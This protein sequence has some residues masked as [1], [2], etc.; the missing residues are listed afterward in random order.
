MFR[1]HKPINWYAWSLIL[2]ATLVLLGVNAWQTDRAIR[3]LYRNENSADTTK[4]VLRT[5]KDFYSA[6]QDAELGI[7][8]HLLAQN[9]TFLAPYFESLDKIKSNLL[10]L[11]GYPY[12]IEGQVD[13]VNQ[14]EQLLVNHLTKMGLHINATEEQQRDSYEAGILSPSVLESY[15][16]ME[17]FRHIV[18]QM[19]SLEY[20]LLEQ[21]SKIAAQ[22]Y[23]RLRETMVVAVSVSVI[24]IIL[25]A[26]LVRRTIRAQQLESMRLERMV[27][28][29][30]HQ[31]AHYSEELK[32]SNREL[33]D[34][35]F[36]ASHDLQEPLRKIRT[37][38]DRLQ[39][40]LPADDSQ[41]GDY[42]RRMQKSAE[43][44]SSLIADLLE[45]SRVSTTQ[46]SFTNVDLAEI[47][48]EVT[49]NLELKIAD[50]HAVVRQENLPTIEADAP[51]MRQLF[52]NL[53]SNALKFVKDGQP[54]EVLI[55]CRQIVHKN[56][57]AAEL[58]FSDNGIGIDP[59]FAE[60]IFTPFQRL[61]G[62]DQYE[63]TGI[64]LAICRRIVERHNGR[65]SVT[66]NE[67]GGST[68]HIILPLH[69]GVVTNAPP[70]VTEQ[71]THNAKS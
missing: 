45:F 7:R 62:R 36:V 5:I 70:S 32:A 51:Q 20:D 48:E 54:P 34:F 63:G 28:R 22:S 39:M 66:S 6:V 44:M 4:A 9:D 55:T 1:H 23:A 25:I 29:R 69:P 57:E 18:E 24:L 67:Q 52:Q 64:G 31:L 37:F 26:L 10:L 14:L 19:E 68:F 42:I 53:I 61:H 27:E 46:R 3:D 40:Q 71:A 17:N 49:E 58:I 35:A 47:F 21:Q 11:K 38:G 59:Q 8:G 33:Q 15:Q 65:I 60:K 43:R 2:I 41:A 16:W 30:T 13:R 56:A 50:T 12:Q